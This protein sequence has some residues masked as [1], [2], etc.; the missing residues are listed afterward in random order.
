MR[1]AESPPHRI[2]M[3]TW[4]V[5]RAPRRMLRVVVRRAPRSP[6]RVDVDDPEQERRRRQST[7]PLG[8]KVAIVLGLCV[9]VFPVVWLGW[10]RHPVDVLVFG[11][12][13]LLAVVLWRS[14]S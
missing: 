4:P 7:W 6:S 11:V 9:I 13:L 12:M 5:G 3:T 14:V 1:G 10:Q 2:F 8:A